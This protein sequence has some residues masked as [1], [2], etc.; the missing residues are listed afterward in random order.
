[1]NM[2]QACFGAES[3]AFS[4]D[5]QLTSPEINGNSPFTSWLQCA[6]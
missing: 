3:H 2:L 5:L 1:M 6:Y 4:I